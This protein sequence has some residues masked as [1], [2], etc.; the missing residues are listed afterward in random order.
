MFP[1]LSNQGT[2]LQERL[3]ALILFGTFYGHLF[4]GFEV[5]QQPAFFNFHENAYNN[6]YPDET[7][8]MHG[9]V[10]VFLFFRTIKRVYGGFS[11]FG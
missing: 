6:G 11:R 2:Q 8:E 3:E 9:L 10:H 7:G 5:Q 4:N 1:P